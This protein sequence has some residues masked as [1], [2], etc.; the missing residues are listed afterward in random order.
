[1]YPGAIVD[2]TRIKAS[3]QMYASSGA[4]V[5]WFN[6]VWHSKEVYPIASSRFDSS[7]PRPGSRARS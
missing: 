4:V 7:S 2:G 6:H 1:M 5:R 3:L